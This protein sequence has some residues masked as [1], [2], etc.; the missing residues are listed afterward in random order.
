MFGVVCLPSQP[1][2][3]QSPRGSGQL[4][5]LPTTSWGVFREICG[6]HTP[7]AGEHSPHGVR[8]SPGTG[9]DAATLRRF[10][11]W[12]VC[13]PFQLFHQQKWDRLSPSLCCSPGQ[14]LPV[15]V[16]P[17]QWNRR[18]GVY[19]T[20]NK[21]RL[22]VFEVVC[23]PFQLFHRQRM[24]QQ[25]RL[26]TGT[27][28]SP[29]LPICETVVWCGLTSLSNVSAV[30]ISSRAKRTRADSGWQAGPQRTST[31]GSGSPSAWKM[32]GTRGIWSTP[33]WP[34]GWT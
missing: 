11:S 18:N 28:T 8:H 13:W 15:P 31:S 14:P 25:D 20:S 29:V 22:F 9:L 33:P 16:P 5:C 6:N 34:T 23:L 1:F 10:C 24:E 19:T 26:C 32:S 7:I 4:V 2:H 3:Q 21:K 12:V 17:W 27:L 30:C